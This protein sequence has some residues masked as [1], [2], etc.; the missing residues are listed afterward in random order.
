[1][2]SVQ[3]LLMI[4]FLLQSFLEINQTAVRA[5]EWEVFCFG[6]LWYVGAGDR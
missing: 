6:K 3:V 1:M 2:I 5:T 4:Q